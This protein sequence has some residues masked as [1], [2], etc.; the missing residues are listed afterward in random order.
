MN[1]KF[2]IATF[3]TRDHL[4]RALDHIKD[5]TDLDVKRAAIVAK[6]T[7]G[8]TL[9]LRDDISAAEAG[10]A[11]GL[12]GMLITLL[13]LARMGMLASGP[14]PEMALMLLL[15]AM[16][17]G[18][19][20][21]L[22]A[23][24]VARLLEMSIRH[25][26]IEALAARLERGSLALVLQITDDLATTSRLRQALTPFQADLTMRAADYLVGRRV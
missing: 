6:A 24:I 1:D 22:T 18:L 9:V 23:R 25:P 11:G 14:L 7:D 10:V 2:V 13:G 17:G 21:A 26:E 4:T 16:I 15:G 20:G 12:L 5:L 19:L 3:P 8:E